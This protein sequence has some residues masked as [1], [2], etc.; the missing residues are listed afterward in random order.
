MIIIKPTTEGDIYVV[1]LIKLNN[2]STS[3]PISFIWFLLIKGI[4][5]VTPWYHSS[6][7]MVPLWQHYVTIKVPHDGTI[8]VLLWYYDQPSLAYIRFRN[9]VHINT[10]AVIKQNEYVQPPITYYK[11]QDT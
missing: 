4:T 11:I 10:Q 3:H 8:M 9:D 7:T 2:E 1:Q 6:T 5:M